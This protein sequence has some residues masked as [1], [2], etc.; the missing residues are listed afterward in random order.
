LSVD[1]LT[2]NY[3]W[4]TPYQ[5]AGNTPVQAVDQ[6]GKEPRNVMTGKILAAPSESALKRLKSTDYNFWKDLLTFEKTY[7]FKDII[8]GNTNIRRQ[9]MEKASGGTLNTDY[10][11][12]TI[13]KLPPGYSAKQLN[14]L[15][16]KNLNAFMD[17]SVAIFYP[18]DPD[19]KKL[20]NSSNPTGAVMTFQNPMDNAGV[21]TSKAGRDYWVF[22]PIWSSSDW[23]HPLAG[24]REFGLTDNTN[25]TYTFY[26]RG[27]DR[28]WTPQDAI[29]NWSPFNPSKW[30]TGGAEKFFNQAD[31]LWNAVIDQVVLFI[32]DHGGSASKTT[33]F[34]R[35]IDWK[36]VSDKDK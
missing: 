5:F 6:D 29:Y 16:R 7:S 20:W 21:V 9:E 8:D 25:G 2:K 4:Y 30:F 13:T 34:N 18:T 17:F 10:Y 23:R 31:Q 28:M 26:T 3:P 19:S 32:N 27:V 11:A 22:T 24:H 36:N 12:A 15:I 14:N 33:S 35:R 1:P